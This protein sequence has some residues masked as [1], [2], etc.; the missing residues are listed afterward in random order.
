VGSVF[1]QL[2]TYV[3]IPMNARMM[4]AIVKVLTD[5]LGILAIATKEIDQN[6][7]S[8]FTFEGRLTH[9]DH[10]STETFLKKLVGRKDI[11]DAIQRLEKV[12]SWEAQIAATEGLNGLHAVGNK[13]Q[14]RQVATDSHAVAA[15]GSKAVYGVNDDSGRAEELRGA[16]NRARIPNRTSAARDFVAR[17]VDGKQIILLIAPN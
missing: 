2:E 3:N 1:R 7:A 11:E 13:K 10:L 14:R 15:E 4:D 17:T 12:T 6:P 16:R 8:K 5:V 9:L